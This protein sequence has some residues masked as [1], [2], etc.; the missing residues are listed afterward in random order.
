M[1]DIENVIREIVAEYFQTINHTHLCMEAID[2]VIAHP[3]I[4]AHILQS[5]WQDIASAPKDGRWIIAS[6]SSSNLHAVHV[7]R[8]LVDW[9]KWEQLD[10]HT[11]EHDPALWL[12]EIP[13][14]PP[15]GGE[16]G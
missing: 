10:H 13:P 12:C 9:R 15:T 1:A 16:H 4:R 5:A 7:A 2:A 3:A 14:L 8:F 6:W 11:T